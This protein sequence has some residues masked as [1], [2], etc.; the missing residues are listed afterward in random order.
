VRRLREPLPQAGYQV[1]RDNF[2]WP[3]HVLRLLVT[4]GV[5]AWLQ[6]NSVCDPACGDASIL[7]AAH[8]L[9]PF[10]KAFLSD[11]SEP[12]VAALRPTFPAVLEVSDAQTALERL[13]ENVDV[14]VLTEILEHIEDPGLLI[15]AARDRAKYLVASS[16]IDEQEGMGNHEHV[17]SWSR[18]S[19]ADMLR[20]ES[21]RPKTYT[22][23]DFPG[24]GYPYTYQLWACW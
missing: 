9:R 6:P 20:A 4:A 2:A 11:I 16:P 10:H 15:R 1:V 8:R 14:I 19:Y 24:S 3:D 5:V 7:E 12:Q 17:W 13:P 21:W 18:Q 22:E 23:I